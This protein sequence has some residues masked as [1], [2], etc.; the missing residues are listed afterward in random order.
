VRVLVTGGAGF[1]GSHVVDKLLEAGHEPL[2]FDLRP[3]PYHPAGDVEQS[4]GDV[5][6]RAAL[7]R[8]ARG[9]DVVV[10]L[11]AVADVADVVATPDRAQRFNAQGTLEILEVAREAGLRRVIY[12]STTWVYS[13]CVGRRV[14]EETPV[15]APSHLYTATKLAG[16]LYCQAY[17]QLFGIEYTILRFGIPYGPRARDATVVAALTEKAERGEPL[18]I[19]GDGT[20]SRRFVYVEDLA[21]G[22]VAALSPEAANRVYNLAGEEEVSVLDIAEAVRTEVRDTGIVHTPARAAD[23]DGKQVSSER[24]TRELGWTARTHFADGF[25]RYL[26]WRRT[27]EHARRVLILSADIGEGHDLPARALAARL[28]EESPAVTVQVVDGLRAMGR[29][30]TLVV[31]DGSWLAFNWLPWLFEAQYFLIARFPPTRWLTMKLGYIF[32]ARRLRKRVLADDPDVIVSTYPGTTAMLGELRRQ[33]RLDIPLVSA[34]TDLAGLRFWAHPGVDLHTVTHFESIEEVEDIAGPGS[35]RWAQPPTSPEFL[36][37]RS[38]LEA[39]R[40]LELPANGKVVVVSGGGWGIGDLEG[41]VRVALER[42]GTFVVCLRGHGKRARRRLERRFGSNPRVRLL[43]F[44]DQMSDLLAAADGLVHSTAG[45]TVLEAQIRGCPVI[46]YG[47]AVGHIRANNRAYERF[48]LARVATSPAALR[49]ELGRALAERPSP[50]PAFAALPSPARL[51]LEAKARVVPLPAVRLR[52]ARVATATAL[53]FLLTGTLLLTDYAYPVFA[54]LLDLSP[55]THV[56]TA[57]PEVGLL[58][59]SPS[60]AT[61]GVAHQLSRRGMHASFAISEP[62]SPAALSA[63]RRSGDDALPMLNSGGLAHTLGTRG[64]LIHA[65]ATLGLGKRFLYEPGGDF[66]LGQDLLGHYAGGSPVRG[67]VK[68]NPG[69]MIGPLSAGE[70]VELEAD[71]GAAGWTST[72]DSLRRSLARGGLSGVTVSQLVGSGGN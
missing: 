66:T 71:P 12:A 40:R 11:A 27:R 28:R 21:A 29:L 4:V 31:R 35:A 48:G 32:G 43:G 36:A 34:I 37:S 8:A 63:L 57:Q 50:D 23:F 14:D 67:E 47:F 62:S 20:Q 61:A 30:L 5:T 9:C 3:S 17:G 56:T 38:R 18:T 19:A 72:L 55:M 13:D 7:E 6:D 1:I 33:G 65:A 39:R 58:I 69:D 26:A 16:E 24:A 52:A 2:V 25:R 51:V 60:Q 49:R 46:S 44:T 42:E 64:R 45:L 41:A 15:A 53:S 70:I 59:D 10:H 68:A 22:V 54:K